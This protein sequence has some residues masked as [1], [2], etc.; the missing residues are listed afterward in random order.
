MPAQLKISYQFQLLI[1]VA[2]STHSKYRI[3][4]SIS[5]V[6]KFIWAL[7]H[8]PCFIGLNAKYEAG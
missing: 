6:H 5:I 7:I 4:V 3:Q 1:V 8:L 2:Y